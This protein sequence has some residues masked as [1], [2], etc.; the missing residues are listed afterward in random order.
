[1]DTVEQFIAQRTDSSGI[2]DITPEDWKYLNSIKTK[3]EI[4]KGLAEY[5][6]TA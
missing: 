1:M 4:R 5:I 6:S 2:P 3:D